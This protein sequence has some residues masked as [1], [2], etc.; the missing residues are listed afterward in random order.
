LSLLATV[1]VALAFQPLRRRVVRVADRLAYGN[2][3]AP[4]E[5]LADFSRR[6]GRSPAPG[7]LLPTIAA[8][9][10]EAVHAD[11]VV[12]RL[13]GEG[14]AELT[15]TWPSG[16]EISD[17]QLAVPVQDQAGVL[18]SIDLSLPPG[19]DVRPLEHR[20]L[21]DI[22]EQAALALRNVHLE[23]ELATHVRE[24]DERTRELTA[25]RN[26]IIGAADTERQRLESA[27][28]RQV[29]PTMVRL[30]T[31][32][33]DS[34]TSGIR[35][36]RIEQCVDHATDA[37]ET[38][39]ELTRGVYPTMLTR[40]GL[41]PALSSYASRALRADVVRIDPSVAVARFP[42]RVEAAAYFCCVDALEHA[43]GSIR[44]GLS[45][46]GSELVVSLLGVD[47]DALDRL[48]IVDRVEACEGSLAVTGTSL[49]ISLPVPVA[50]T[51]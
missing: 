49:R 29:L 21:T 38:L 9:A 12:V 1:V 8:A 6:I 26:R 37:L 2:R 44:V 4:Y 7:Q 16:T 15:A 24:L 30:R 39:R 3:A 28:A 34:A 41:G 19:R 25:S 33:E 27:I 5:A 42:D 31:E 32:V 35:V 10:G 51:A 48:A 50:V 23:I 40:S 18:G 43:A 14:G 45:D 11:Q 46:G 22:A 20:L 36:E 17:H 13:D 47:L